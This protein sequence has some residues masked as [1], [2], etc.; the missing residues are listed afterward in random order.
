[1]FGP[2]DVLPCPSESARRR[3]A[4][5]GQTCQVCEVTPG[6]AD[7]RAALRQAEDNLFL[8][9]RLAEVDRVIR[10]FLQ[11]PVIR[12]EALDREHRRL[13]PQPRT[14]RRSAA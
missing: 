13:F 12:H 1:M 6:A 9:R 2:N 4:A 5:H 14:S 10:T 7:E 8:T 11:F 3:H